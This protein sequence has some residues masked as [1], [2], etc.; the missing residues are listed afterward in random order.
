M[1][2]VALMFLILVV[3]SSCFM[4][5]SQKKKTC[6][7]TVSQLME[8]GCSLKELSKL[9][10]ISERF[11][12]NPTKYSFNE[13]DSVLLMSLANTY[14]QSGKLPTNLYQLYDKNN[15]SHVLE[16]IENFRQ[17]ELN[18]NE[19]FINEANAKISNL[20]EDNLNK[21]VD[22]EINSIK[23]LRFTWKSED[24]IKQTLE[25]TLPGYIKEIEL[26]KTYNDACAAHFNRI[27]RFR[28]NGVKRYIAKVAAKSRLNSIETD[29]QGFMPEYKFENGAAHVTYQIL[30]T[31]E[32]V[33]DTLFKPINWLLGLLPNW[34]MIAISIILVVLLVV[35]LCTGQFHLG[36]LDIVLLAISV[37]VLIW[38]DPYAEI[39]ES[40]REQI[41]N[42]YHEKTN[43]EL[44]QLNVNT[45]AYYDNLLKTLQIS[46]HNSPSGNFHR[47]PASIKKDSGEDPCNNLKESGEG[48]DRTSCKESDNNVSKTDSIQ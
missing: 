11:I 10:G 36:L 17:E 41:Q 5:C 43:N 19:E 18:S 23:S 16:V 4:G 35:F 48:D 22:G 27:A 13:A 3:F 2:K 32:R 12:K 30:A 46:N 25:E 14:Y 40:M 47:M 24:E 33:Q 38:G 34:L 28:E 9:L 37:I 7:D 44:I 26:A 31:V 29:L 21:F 1:K 42:Y 8:D 20:Q 15:N 45:N 39:R 6:A